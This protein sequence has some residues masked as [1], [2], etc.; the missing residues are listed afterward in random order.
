MYLIYGEYKTLSPSAFWVASGFFLLS[1][2]GFSRL[3]LFFGMFNRLGIPW[4]VCRS[5]FSAGAGLETTD[6]PTYKT[7]LDTV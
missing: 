2:V 7:L 3:S 1:R 6:D 5:L 4:Y